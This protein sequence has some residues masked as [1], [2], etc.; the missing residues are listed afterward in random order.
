MNEITN[1]ISV[2]FVAILCAFSTLQAQDSIRTPYFPYQ[3]GD[4]WVNEI[5][6]AGQYETDE[7]ID[8]ISDS[9]A[10][11]G[12]YVFTVSSDRGQPE[13]LI[14][15]FK[16]DSTNN[17]YSDLWYDKGDWLKIF[18]FSKNVGETWILEQDSLTPCSIRTCRGNAGI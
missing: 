17:I 5:Y 9:A 8:I 12:D 7:R 3:S 4:F 11:N 2:L 13:E 15:N 14:Y 18:D 10:P 1:I 16:I 6:I